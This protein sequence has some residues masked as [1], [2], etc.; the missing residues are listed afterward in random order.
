MSGLPPRPCPF[1]VYEYPCPYEKNDCA[2]CDIKQE[3][4]SKI[5]EDKEIAENQS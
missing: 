5:N 2:G 4:Q 1:S 3:A